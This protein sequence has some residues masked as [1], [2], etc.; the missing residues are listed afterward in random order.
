MA[1]RQILKAQASPSRRATVPPVNVIKLMD[2]IGGTKNRRQAGRFHHLLYKAKNER[3]ISQA[4]ELAA[5][6]R[7]GEPGQAGAPGGSPAPQV[8]SFT[9]PR[10]GGAQRSWSLLPADKAEM[11]QRMAAAMGAERCVSLADI[12]GVV[13]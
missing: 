1:K 10:S 4:V 5:A 13:L 8:S 3:A 7:I 9:A 6:M 12:T 11:F 2:E